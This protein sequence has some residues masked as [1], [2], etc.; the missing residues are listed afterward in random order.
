M[1]DILTDGTTLPPSWVL[2]A[3]LVIAVLTSASVKSVTSTDPADLEKLKPRA[4]KL[5]LMVSALLSLLVVLAQQVTGNPDVTL[6]GLMITGVIAFRGS[7]SVADVLK[8]FGVNINDLVLPDKGIDP[9]RAL[10][11]SAQD[12]IP[13]PVPEGEY[14]KGGPLLQR[15]TQGFP[16]FEMEQA[17]YRRQDRP[18]PTQPRYTDSSFWSEG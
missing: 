18:A 2:Y 14:G 7:G 3:P 16:V 13:R 15:E 9:E 17:H 8:H 4:R 10:I 5:R 1:I 11:V 6:G 12:P